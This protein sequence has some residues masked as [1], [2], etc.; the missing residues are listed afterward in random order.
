MAK[1]KKHELR[2]YVSAEDYKR[3]EQESATRNMSISNTVKTCLSEYLN[4]KKELATSLEDCGSLGDDQSGK[5]IHTL[6]MRTEERVA[7][8]IERL[9]ERIGYVSEQVT[10]L[11]AMIDRMYLGIMAHLPELPP[12][13]NEA[14]M[15]SSK[16]RHK[17]WLD[18]TE[19]M[20]VSERD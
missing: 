3:I 13:L 18:A 11:T 19:K 2:S 1:I 7:A 12:E 8:T 16:R 9:E 4:L 10:V 15:A 20:V 6:L 5:I 17:K 14:A